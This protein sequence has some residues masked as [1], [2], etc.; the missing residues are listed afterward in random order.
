MKEQEYTVEVCQG[1]VCHFLGKDVLPE[2][3]EGVSDLNAVTT[4]EG[5]CK[6]NC[7]SATNVYVYRN[8][9]LKKHFTRVNR[10]NNM[11]P[12]VDEVITSI[13]S[14]VSPDTSKNT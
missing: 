9:S 1:Q 11:G 6:R 12:T 7:N 5:W 10:K 4:R 13:K 8:E 2:I 14:D 3:T